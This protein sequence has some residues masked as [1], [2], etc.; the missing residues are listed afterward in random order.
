M[1]NEVSLMGDESSGQCDSCGRDGWRN[2]AL[3]CD[4]VAVREAPEH[5]GDGVRREVLLIRRGIEPWKGKW[6]FPGGFVEYGEE[7]EVAVLREL[8]E[9]TGVIGRNPKVIGV[10]G[11]GDRDPRKHIVTV[12]YS[13]S[14][15]S[16]A[17]P[18]AGDDAADAAWI[19]IDDIEAEGVA[20]DHHEIIRTL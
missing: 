19:A 7:P 3:T 16:D 2:P 5:D 8:V 12:F 4:A 6:A 11:A 10:R 17:V 15:D 14:V 20:G 9:E 1:V 18:I 13:V